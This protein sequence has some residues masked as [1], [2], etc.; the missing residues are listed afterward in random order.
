MIKAIFFDIDGTL[1][2]HKSKRIPNS[3]IDAFKQLREKGVYLFAATGRHMLEME[4]LPLECLEF[5]GYITLNGQL[6]LNASKEIMDESP[7]AKEDTMQMVESFNE[8]KVPIMI[9]EKNR[10]Y[11]NFA[12]EQV[13]E[14]QELISSPIP[15]IGNYQGDKIYQFVIYDRDNQAKEI[16]KKLPNC[17]MVYW[18]NDAIDVIPKDGGK[19]IGIQNVIKKL[20]I[21]REET[22]A[23][24]DGHNDIDMLQFVGIG[25][26][27]GNSSDDVKKEADYITDD[28]DCDGL[29]KALKE[30]KVI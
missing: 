21:K 2:S 3:T 23:F 19:A 29:Y 7:I 10:M 26:A 9:V 22:M 8:K 1:L 12:D 16:Q 11:I 5:D 27:M 28:I 6:S 13:K 17:T 30:Y 18:N 20:G 24:G 25:V 15:E 14:A 4:Q